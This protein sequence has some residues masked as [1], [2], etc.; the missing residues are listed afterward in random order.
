M[1]IYR[2]DNKIWLQVEQSSYD[3]RIPCRLKPA[4]CSLGDHIYLFGGER[5]LAQG[6]TS[7]NELLKDF[8]QL[9]IINRPMSSRPDV[10]VKEVITNYSPSERAGSLISLA[11]RY[12]VLWGG[13]NAI[14]SKK[15]QFGFWVYVVADINW[16]WV[17]VPG[18]QPRSMLPGWSMNYQN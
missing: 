11:D 9:K 15:G 16:I 4:L 1:H 2:I 14:D 12:L 8:Y 18:T 7:R 10:W 5:R 6:S 17:S 3:L 13:L